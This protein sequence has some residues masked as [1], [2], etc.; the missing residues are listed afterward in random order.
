MSET[1]II[2][3]VPDEVVTAQRTSEL[4]FARTSDD[5]AIL[6]QKFIV[7][8]YTRGPSGPVMERR[9]EWR[10]VPVVDVREEVG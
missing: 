5:G 3:D 7:E 1:T 9:V 4:R 2:K 10:D 8:S 6:Q